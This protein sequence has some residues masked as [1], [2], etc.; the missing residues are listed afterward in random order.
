M[1]RA[2]PTLKLARV[3]LSPSLSPSFVSSRALLPSSCPRDPTAAATAASLSF[4]ALSFS[5]SRSFSLVYLRVD[6]ELTNLCARVMIRET[7]LSEGGERRRNLPS[8]V[9]VSLSLHLPFFLFRPRSF[10]RLCASRTGMARTVVD[11]KVPGFSLFLSLLIRTGMS[12][13]GV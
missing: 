12:A 7:V 6:R 9:A 13:P 1:Q 3:R 4:F 10:R 11:A 2:L 5:R 8:C